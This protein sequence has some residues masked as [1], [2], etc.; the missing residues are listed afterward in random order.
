VRAPTTSKPAA[1]GVQTAYRD[2][3]G[4]RKM[5][6]QQTVDL[7]LAALGA[8]Q[9]G[10]PAGGVPLVLRESARLPIPGA[11]E[12]RTEDARTVRIE[13]GVAGGVPPGY[14]ELLGDDGATRPLIVTPGRCRLPSTPR[15]FGFASQ[16]YAARS[17]HSWGIGD[18]ADLAALAAWSTS[19]GAAMLQ[20]NPMHAVLPGIPQ[21][22]S[23]YSPSSRRYRNP[24]YI[25]VQRVPGVE[26]AG[27]D[28][29]PL[30]RQGR[31]LLAQRR[32]DRD[33]VYKLK[34]SVLER[35]WE[36]LGDVA[37]LDGFIAAD[38][39]VLRFATFCT[40]FEHH[41][42]SWREWPSDV[43]S[44]DAAG[45]E[46]FRR[47][48]RHRVRFHVWLQWL[49][50]A[51]VRDAAGCGALVNDL[52]VGFDADGADAWE[53]QGQWIDGAA[54][55]A[56]PDEFNTLGQ[57]W[58]LCAFDPWRLR[59]AGYRPFIET[60]RAALRHASGLRIDH[61]MGLFRLFLVPA[62]DDPRNGAYITYPWDD[63]L[64][65]VALESH[66]AGAY[67]V[68]EDLGTVEPRVRR[69]LARRDVLSYR[70]LWFEDDDPSAYP[71]KALCA[72]TTH[73]LPTVAGLWSGSDL[74]AQRELGLQ[75]NEPA[76]R[77]I[78]ER[79]IAA[80]GIDPK[81]SA[82]DAVIAVHALI[83]KSRSM[84]VSATLDDLLAV[85][86]RP[87]MPGTDRWPNWSLALPVPIEELMAAP[88]ASKVA[89][90]LRRDA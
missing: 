60:I 50:D 17:R 8:D 14:H 18:L 51:Q 59:A 24:I 31:A 46:R 56:P 33:A 77:A 80:T 76:I 71:R 67:I 13:G 72:V 84:L 54:V 79:I 52:A 38:P 86:E 66:R 58:G 83:A 40:L 63:L 81:A 37:G 10:P 87:N 39:G 85:E 49:L 22:P 6:P 41:R 21:Q 19:V 26:H 82:E 16:L 2:W 64:G 30:A 4:R 15:T 20:V 3:A 88:L 74:R 1:W 43:V 35:I 32:I 48:H 11:V 69:E 34:L 90:L 65:I 47:D 55:G 53:W 68:G 28:V 27:V 70:L 75:P 23:P 73:D 89:S 7:L 12:I 57:N 61:V 45:I 78:R 9:D 29:E 62:R 36:L 44:P 25:S 42:T 5:V